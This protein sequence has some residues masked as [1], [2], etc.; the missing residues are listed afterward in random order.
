MFR[1]LMQFALSSFREGF[2]DPD[3]ERALAY[4]AVVLTF[5]EIHQFFDPLDH[6][7][8]ELPPLFEEIWH[9]HTHVNNTILPEL[10]R[11]SQ[12]PDAVSFEAP[13][14]MWMNFLK[15]LSDVGKMNF[16]PLFKNKKLIPLSLEVELC[17]LKPPRS[18]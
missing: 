7:I 4:F 11:R 14:E 10:F 18:T 12:L 15:E 5:I 17:K 9:I 1:A 8:V 16:V 2:F 6:P 3:S 13:Q